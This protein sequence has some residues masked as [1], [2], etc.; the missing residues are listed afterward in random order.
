MDI[1]QYPLPC[2]EDI[3]STLAGGKSFSK[4]DLTNAY[5]QLQYYWRM[6]QVKFVTVNMSRGLYRYTQLPL[7]WPQCQHFSK[8]YVIRMPMLYIVY[9]MAEMASLQQERQNQLSLSKL[10]VPLKKIISSSK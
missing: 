4:L 1:D 7:V 3:F 6:S 10:C 8:D 2:A 5:Q 9:K